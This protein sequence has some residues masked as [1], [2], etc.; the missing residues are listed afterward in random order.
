MN[1]IVFLGKK[2]V[3]LR[4]WK[5]SK[6][7]LIIES[8]DWGSERTRDKTTLQQLI[9]INSMVASDAM[10]NLDTIAS[11]EDL[12]F[13]FEV[14]NS[15]K[16]YRNH[17]AKITINV[18]TANPDFEQ[19]KASGF[20]SFYYK[21]FHQSILERPRGHEIL[22]L[23]NEGISQQLFYPQLHGREH[24]HALA[25]LAELRASNPELLRA[26]ELGTWG[27]PYNARLFS[28]RQNL[29]AALDLYGIEGELQFQNSWIKDSV[30]IFKDYFGFLP[31]TFIPPAYTWH[32][33]IYQ[34]VCE[35]GIKG[36]QGIGLQYQ[37]ILKRKKKYY[38]KLHITGSNLG[39][40]VYRI[41]RNAFYE[42]WSAPQKD[43]ISSCLKSIDYAFSNGMPAIMGAHR[44]NFIGSLNERNR[45]INLKNFEEILSRI[46]RLWPD[47]EFWSSDEL[48]DEI[49][50]Y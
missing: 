33:Q 49:Q 32:S 39:E 38:K 15:K 7:I 8:D 23:W 42:Q 11:I 45:D 44:V 1:P 4:S 5:T 34:A 35:A 37:P 2:W 9:P 27:I 29:Q 3:T 36:I 31:K 50:K 43:W 24:V 25:W 28:R 40:G 12:A 47:V 48:I 41:S 46:L 6:R 22:K 30:S 17:P 21:P 14:L 20:Q 13:L 26:F 18:C 19:I 10:S 16:D